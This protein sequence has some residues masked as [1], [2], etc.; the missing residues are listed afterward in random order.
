MKSIHV[1]KKRGAQI[2]SSHRNVNRPFKL[3]IWINNLRKRR[4]KNTRINKNL[5]NTH[6]C[7]HRKITYRFVEHA[8]LAFL[9]FAIRTVYKTI[10]QNMIIYASI[11]ALSI[12]CW[13][14]KSLHSIHRWWTFCFIYTQIE[15]YT[16]DINDYYYYSYSEKFQQTNKTIR[17]N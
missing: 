1:S 14:S 15:N 8:S 17:M 3:N 16:V 13:T 10:A 9:I 7:V 4:K 2:I 12:W 5:T 11:S 6:M